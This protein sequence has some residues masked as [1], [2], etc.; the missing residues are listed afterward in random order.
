MRKKLTTQI[1]TLY[2]NLNTET[3]G[4]PHYTPHC[5]PHCT[6][7]YSPHCSPHYTPHCTPH[8]TPHCTPLCSPHY[9]PHC[10]PHY[11]P[12]CSP[13]CSSR[14]A[15]L[16]KTKPK[17]QVK[18]RS[19][20]YCL[21]LGVL[22]TPAHTTCAHLHILPAHTYTHFRAHLHTLPAHTTYTQYY[23]HTPTHAFHMTHH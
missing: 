14:V 19:S 16:R 22:R 3:M 9:T 5:S 1:K 8:Y 17:K 13:H 11:S 21:L 20:C 12:H 4:C 18:S 23:T 6:P 15:A 7:Y 2:L 10:T